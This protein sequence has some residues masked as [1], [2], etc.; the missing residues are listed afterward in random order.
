LNEVVHFCKADT[1]TDVLTWVVFVYRKNGQK[2]FTLLVCAMGA[3]YADLLCRRK[4]FRVFH[5]APYKSFA[6]P[7]VGSGSEFL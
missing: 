6:P 4:R 1:E 5:P 7:P 3:Q 2:T